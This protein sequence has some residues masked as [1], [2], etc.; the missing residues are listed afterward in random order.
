M[1]SPNRRF[2]L[3]FLIAVLGCA[4]VLTNAPA[5]AQPRGGVRSVTIPVTVR[6]R[7]GGAATRELQGVGDLTVTEDGDEQ[8]ILSL[9]AYGT[10][11]P[12]A[13]GIL[14]QDDVV[15]SISNEIKAMREFVGRL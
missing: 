9:R 3:L 1:P 5:T 8:R 2:S 11:T 7:G 14:I 15:S 12:L 4:A 10:D 6:Q 13:V